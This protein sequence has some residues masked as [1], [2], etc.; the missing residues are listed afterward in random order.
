MTDFGQAGMDADGLGLGVGVGCE[1]LE[2]L[3]QR[4]EG[5]AGGRAAVVISGQRLSSKVLV[6]K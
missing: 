5:F 6:G 4:N 2:Y 1:L 3:G